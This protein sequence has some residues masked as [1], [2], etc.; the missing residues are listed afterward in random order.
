LK[1]KRLGPLP[2]PPEGPCLLMVATHV[3]LQR[4]P[5]THPD[6]KKGGKKVANLT[7][8]YWEG[9]GVGVKDK[10]QRGGGVIC[11][12]NKENPKEYKVFFPSIEKKARG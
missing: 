11:T 12:K 10:S 3:D 4:E 2:V 8:H 9:A 6:Q 7:T 5:L 1:K